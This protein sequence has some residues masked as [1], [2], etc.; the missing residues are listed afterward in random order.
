MKKTYLAVFAGDV[1]SYDDIKITVV[2]LATD[3]ADAHFRASIAANNEFANNYDIDPDELA[4]AIESGN[5]NVSMIEV[6]DVAVMIDI[7]E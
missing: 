5:V 7:A 1:E 3:E 4:D 2:I 6:T